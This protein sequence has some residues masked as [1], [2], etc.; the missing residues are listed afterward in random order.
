VRV[1]ECPTAFENFTYHGSNVLPRAMALGVAS[2]EAVGLRVYVGRGGSPVVVGPSGWQCQVEVWPNGDIALLAV[3][4]GAFLGFARGKLG[5]AKSLAVSEYRTCSSCVLSAACPF[6]AAAR[7]ASR[8]AFGAN[9]GPGSCSTAPKGQQE[10]RLS[11][12]A[13]A[14]EDPP[15]VFGGPNPAEGV[16]AFALHPK[17]AAT[18][19]TCIVPKAQH[20][21]CA[22]DFD[23]VLSKDWQPQLAMAPA[24]EARVKAAPVR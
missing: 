15:S 12:D 10:A 20:W 11:A 19:A 16:A 13:V 9:P 5:S 4:P 8:R 17:P 18:V 1:T 24:T 7:A 6:F 2:P 14:F 3:P 23:L 21:L 22:V